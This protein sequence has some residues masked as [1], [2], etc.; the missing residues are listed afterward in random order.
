MSDDLDAL[1]ANLTPEQ[2][3]QLAARL[4]GDLVAGDKISGD[5][6]AG[7]KISG[8]QAT[9]SVG[10]E[11][12]IAGG[13]VG[14][15]LGR[16][17]YG[18]DPQEDERR[19]L[20]W[21]LEGLAARLYELP[22]RGLD[23]RLSH[24]DGLAMPRVYVELATTR[25]QLFKS[26]PPADL[27][28][29]CR[30]EQVD[31]AVAPGTTTPGYRITI[32]EPYDQDL[33]LPSKALLVADVHGDAEQIF[34]ARQLL[35]TKA[36]QQSARLVLLGDPGSGKSTFLRHLA[37][38]LAQRE[39]DAEQ[40]PRLPGWYERKQHLPIILPLRKLAAR[41]K[42]D[43][44]GDAILAALRDEMLSYGTHQV[45]D[46]LSAAL[47]RGAA[48]LLFDGLD[49]VPPDGTPDLAARAT[50]LRAVQDAAR[51]FKR[52]TVV[53]SCRARAFDTAL[54]NQLGWQVATL[55]PLT[56]GQMRHFVAAWYGEL[57]ARG[58]ISAE[59]ASRLG[60]Q[61]VDSI[62]ASPKLRAM[63]E[64]PLLLTMMAL[65]LYNKGELP[66]DRPQLYE[67][68]LELLLGQ[69]DKVRDGQSLAEAIGLPDWGSERVRPLLDRLS[70]DAHLHASSEDGRGR[71]AR[72]A[73]YTALI[74]FFKTARV[75]Q[76]G[77]IALRCLDYFEQRSGLL[78]PDEQDSYVF[79]H[80]TLQEHC[81]GRHIALGGDDPVALAMRHRAE[82]R[83]REPIFL[84]AG[85]LRPAELSALL[86]DLIDAEEGGRPKS[87]QRRQRDLILAAE[88]GKDRDWDYLRTRPLI[89]VDRLQRDLRRGLVGLLAD[90]A[91][92][93]P[94]AE[95]VRAGFLLGELGDPR[96]PVALDEWKVE[97]AR[98]LAGDARGYFCRVEAGTYI[99]GS[100]DDDP[101]AE[102]HEKPQHSVT[103][104]APF[105]I[106]RYPITNAQW[107][108]WVQEGG[109]RAFY[110]V[111]SHN[112]NYP[113]QPVVG[114]SWHMC[115]DFCAWVSKQVGVTIRLPTEQ[116]W[117]AAARG[118]DARRY[119][120]GDRWHPD[121]AASAENHDQTTTWPVGCYPTGTATCGALD[122]AGNVWEWT[123]SEWC[124]Y[125]RAQEP[126]ADPSCHIVRG[127]S[128][129]RS[130]RNVRCTS[131]FKQQSNVIDEESGVRI[132]LIPRPAP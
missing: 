23:E 45:D 91:Q 96:F 41:L 68:I 124:S 36:I 98:A 27:K 119:P 49:E 5:K 94:V 32:T 112:L 18:R 82:D 97:I 81:A 72:A 61:L 6:V 3:A 28:R 71:I 125:P 95:R 20:V 130:Y 67:R 11:A 17:V 21:Y 75:P 92:P 24:G 31:N 12:Q 74:D 117:E 25:T 47:H 106:G 101:D 86:A 107:E 110:M 105:W 111:D 78:V 2:R 43:G 88:I 69:W 118:G 57:V 29:Y 70:Y 44:E 129:Q 109:K 85:L 114:M 39:L 122:L 14:V 26:G 66:R 83:W 37:W 131:R 48:L 33:V 54:R 35:A 113:N 22:L 77:D 99:I 103:F 51:R 52:C 15:N 58:Q 80:L 79:A 42:R 62:Q 123:A 65:V 13:V 90:K 116:E 73:L 115:N 63:A 56:L 121:H 7:D 30:V 53:I 132:I 40:A 84:G 4:A 126:S 108:T 93:L 38:G 1:L 46:A 55:A 10:A 89:K 102:D 59:Q 127:G 64:N 50:T 34:L 19:R 8:P 104:D 87:A 120:W 60:A 9:I 128:W 100:A 16:I 76:P